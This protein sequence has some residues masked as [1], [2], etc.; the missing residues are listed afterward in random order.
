M[1]RP[2]RT[3][4]YKKSFRVVSPYDLA[5]DRKQSKIF[6]YLRTADEK[7]LTFLPGQEPTYYYIR[8]VPD[9]LFQRTLMRQRSPGEQILLSFIYSVEKVTNDPV[10]GYEW[11]PNHAEIPGP[12]GSFKIMSESDP[13]ETLGLL[14]PEINWI[15]GV[16]YERHFLHQGQ[17]PNY[18][19]SPPL[20]EYWEQQLGLNVRPSDTVETQTPS[21]K[22]K[23]HSSSKKKS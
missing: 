16:A 2:I 3:L 7:F 23:K 14:Q 13:Y 11:T 9:N 21:T 12:E 22:G 1:A 8:Y 15:G 6:K 20:L 4:E 10:L 5:I 19:V 18:Q 17:E